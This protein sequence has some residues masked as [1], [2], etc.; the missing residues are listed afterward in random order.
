M[1][2]GRRGNWRRNR[3]KRERKEERMMTERKREVLSGTSHQRRPSPRP[4]KVD[5]ALCLCRVFVTPLPIVAAGRSTLDSI[6]HHQQERRQLQQRQRQ[7]QP[8]PSYKEDTIA[9]TT[10]VIITTTTIF[11]A[12]CTHPGLERQP[13]SCMTT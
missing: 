3:S 5:I 9:T 4:R 12:Y 13:C 2:K 6:N 8:L 11:P 7:Q 1:V 10:T